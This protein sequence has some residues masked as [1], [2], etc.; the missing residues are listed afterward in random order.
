VR[1]FLLFLALGL[2]PNW[3]TAQTFSTG[4]EAYTT[5]SLFVNGWDAG[6]FF[7]GTGD[8]D[9]G[10]SLQSPNLP[11]TTPL[12][13]FSGYW[14]DNGTVDRFLSFQYKA[15]WN[16]NDD[17]RAEFRILIFDL[18]NNFIGAT[19]WLITPTT[20]GSVNNANIFIPSSLLSNNWYYFRIE[21]RRTG[22][23]TGGT[24]IIRFDNF[25]GN[26]PTNAS[27]PELSPNVTVSHTISV[28]NTPI[29]VGDQAVLSFTFEYDEVAPS[30]TQRGVRGLQYEFELHDG[31]DYVSHTITGASAGTSSYNPATSILTIHAVQKG[32]PFTLAITVEGVENC[33]N[34]EVTEVSLNPNVLQPM[35]GFNTA[36]Q[37]LSVLP[38]E[39]IYFKAE[40]ITW[41]RIVNLLWATAS[42][43]DND[44][45]TIERSRDGK[46]FHEIAKVQG[47]GTHIGTLE[48]TF[49]DVTPVEGM[50]Y[51]RL[52]QTDINGDYSYS[53]VVRVNLPFLNKDFTLY[54]NPTSTQQPWNIS[55][56]GDWINN[57]NIQVSI[58][59]SNGNTIWKESMTVENNE[60][61]RTKPLPV[62]TP[63][64]YI[65]SLQTIA[66]R[67][68]KK[69]IVSR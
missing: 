33:E 3:V 48:Y 57:E 40:A 54:P 59:D 64:V 13:C 32:V 34:C 25:G 11:V 53:Q 35:T 67:I 23:N 8:S 5:D 36:S 28:S 55:L 22:S 20:S 2:L 52:K 10:R 31:L 68:A 14:R 69:L 29:D 50:S 26:L 58:S 21:A 65:I 39:L 19:G 42:E 38:I 16:G 56:S 49:T 44:F 24:S 1:I 66:K 4:F 15:T 12:V 27:W 51:Y 45:F 61:V 37:I 7:I 6:S 30:P 60:L 17:R 63:G 43:K 46:R 18:S 9:F 41:D 62:L 47:A